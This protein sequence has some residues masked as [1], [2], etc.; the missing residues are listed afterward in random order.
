[1]EEGDLLW[2]SFFFS[3][4]KGSSSAVLEWLVS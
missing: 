4:K 2:V 1:M 3:D